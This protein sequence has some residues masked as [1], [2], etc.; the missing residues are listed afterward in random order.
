MKTTILPFSLFFIG[1]NSFAVKGNKNVAD[2]I[3]QKQIVIDEI[4]NEQNQSTLDVNHDERVEIVVNNINPFI[5][6]IT[7]KESQRDYLKEIENRDKTPYS[8][9]LAPLL[10]DIPEIEY[11]SI[12]IPVK[13]EP[14]K[15]K[16][17]ME[18]ESLPNK[19]EDIQAEINARYKEEFNPLF[20]KFM[21]SIDPN[22][23]INLTKQIDDFDY[24]IAPLISKEQ[25]CVKVKNQLQEK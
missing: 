16:T 24:S 1:F 21:S 2:K 6:N 17:D 15:I 20:D 10:F 8:H 19:L 3:R 5:Y 11:G 25:H 13:K 23:K 14:I 9:N 4:S 12:I 22:E 18:V 7:V